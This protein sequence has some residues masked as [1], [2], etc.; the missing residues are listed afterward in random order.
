MGDCLFPSPQ[1]YLT[2]CLEPH[3]VPLKPLSMMAGT[4]PTN[5]QRVLGS[6]SR[7]LGLRDDPGGASEDLCCLCDEGGVIHRH[8]RGLGESRVDI[9]P[10]G[11]LGGYK[12]V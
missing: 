7:C 6:D 5:R 8:R 9:H 12:K 2:F 3:S 10:A 4:R 11:R 1:F